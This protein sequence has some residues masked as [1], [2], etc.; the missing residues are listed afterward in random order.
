MT[1][2]QDRIARTIRE[3]DGQGWH[4]TGTVVDLESA[5]WLAG[6]VREAG[7]EPVLE[8]FNL[9]RVVPGESYLEVG[10]RR[11]EGLP[12]FDGAFTDSD[13][14]EGRLGTQDSEILVVEGPPMLAAETLDAARRSGNHNAIV[15]VTSS[16]GGVAGLA[17]RNAADF[18]EPF[19]PPVL[20][21]DGVERDWLIEQAES[22]V[23]VRVTVQAD[24]ESAE[25][26][27]VAAEILGRGRDL[28]PLVVMTPR[29][30]WWEIAAERGGASSVGWRSC[31]Q[32][33]V[34]SLLATSDL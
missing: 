9:D 32:S 7:A 3:Y 17:P 31:V 15:F 1:T 24:R 13:G 21:V 18:T 27:N 16:I 5:H 19:G 4:R 29:S 14:V 20:Q 30:G 25:A 28:P 26:V 10:G 34:S 8:S 2:I 22:G 11:I 33:K 12:L 23:S 6:L